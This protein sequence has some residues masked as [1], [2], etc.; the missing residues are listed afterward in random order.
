MTRERT[1]EGKVLS[2]FRGPTDSL[3]G[4]LLNEYIDLTL[5]I[6]QE[7][8]E[9]STDQLSREPILT[10]SAMRSKILERNELA[11]SHARIFDLTDRH[12]SIL[13]DNENLQDFHDQVHDFANEA[14]SGSREVEAIGLIHD[15]H[16]GNYYCDDTRPVGD[17]L[18]AIDFGSDYVGPIGHSFAFIVR[19]MP[20]S[21]G[22][23]DASFQQVFANL[24]Q[25]Y[26]EIRGQQLT[27][28]GRAEILRAMVFPPYKFISSDSRSFLAELGREIG[29]P[30][31]FS[32]AELRNALRTPDMLQRLDDRLASEAMRTKHGREL[33]QMRFTLRLLR[34]QSL[35]AG[36][37]SAIDKLLRTIDLALDTEYRLGAVLTRPRQELPAAS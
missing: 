14:W 22:W 16:L 37:A 33:S 31:A 21:A 11:E 3:P 24:I 15:A 7:G 32:T 13:I 28:R 29:L 17:R 9:I 19:E 27:A 5:R 18:T 35:S 36:E 26:A 25:R 4:E 6:A 1:A 10:Y 23:T 34:Q 2:S 30:A 20:P 12:Q 8:A